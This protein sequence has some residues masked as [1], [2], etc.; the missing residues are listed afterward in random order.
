M[1]H[2]HFLLAAALFACGCGDDDDGAPVNPSGPTMSFFVSSATSATGNL[3]GLA[4]ADRRC[5][6]LAAAAGAGGKTWRAY[7]SVERVPAAGR[8]STRATASAAGPGSTPGGIGRPEPRP[9]CTAP[10]DAADLVDERT[11]QIRAMAGIADAQARHP[12]RLAARGTAIH[13][14]R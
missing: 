3:G 7:L 1:K 13:A 6:D 5:Q 8:P 2:T 14:G 12:H 9:S 10:D 11:E 4:G